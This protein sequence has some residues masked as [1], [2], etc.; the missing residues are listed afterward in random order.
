MPMYTFASDA[1]IAA[2]K[3]RQASEDEPFTMTIAT[4]SDTGRKE[5]MTII[6]HAD[7]A[8][9]ILILDSIVGG[10]DERSHER[11]ERVSFAMGPEAFSAMV[12]ALNRAHDTE[13]DPSIAANLL[14]SIAE[15][16]DIEWV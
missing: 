13:A 2:V 11:H 8:G 16:L 3:A 12:D 6:R 5:F 15:S 14:S 1:G 9:R 10:G 4:W 7:S